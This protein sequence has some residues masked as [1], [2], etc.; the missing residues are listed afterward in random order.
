[1]QLTCLALAAYMEAR[2][3]YR[4]PDAMAAVVEV[5]LNRVDDPRWPDT[6]CG[7]IAEPGQ[8]P[9]FTEV[10]IP[11]TEG[12]PDQRAWV[13]AV[14]VA[15]QGRTLG[16]TSTHFHTVGHRLFWADHYEFDGNIGGNAFYTNETEYK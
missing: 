7:V 14:F 12:V 5:V 16:L 13:T 11:D 15:A 2:Q 6:P 4:T 10:R 9:W 8:F 3:H 1:M